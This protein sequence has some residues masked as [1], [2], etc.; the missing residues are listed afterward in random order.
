MTI[1]LS[2]I[3]IDPGALLLT[4]TISKVSDLERLFLAILVFF[5]FFRSLLFSALYANFPQW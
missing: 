1:Y 2:A 5:Y 3:L 4:N